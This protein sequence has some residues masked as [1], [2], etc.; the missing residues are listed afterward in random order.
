MRGLYEKYVIQ[1]ASGEP[2]EPGARYFVLR[3]DNDEDA[4]LA[5]MM[6]AARKQN[7]ELYEELRSKLRAAMGVEEDI[8][9]ADGT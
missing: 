7:W 4:C 3:Y 9:V 5:A 8:G 6:W 1:K 2:L